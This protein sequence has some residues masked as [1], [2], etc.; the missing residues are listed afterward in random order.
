MEKASTHA[1]TLSSTVSWFL[2]YEPHEKL[3]HTPHMKSQLHKNAM[4]VNFQTERVEK[5]CLPH[6][7][8]RIE[9]YISLQAASVLSSLMKFKTSVGFAM[10]GCLMESTL[11]QTF[12]HLCQR[13]MKNGFLSLDSMCSLWLCSRGESVLWDAELP[14]PAW[15]SSCTSGS[16]PEPDWPGDVLW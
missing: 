14:Q 16:G 6:F 1:L 15:A 10:E 9:F 8:H 2:T 5:I 3:A 4:Y 7:R 13:H 12:F 11:W